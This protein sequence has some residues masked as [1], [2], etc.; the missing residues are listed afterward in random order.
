MIFAENFAR[1]YE[2]EIILG[3]SDAW[4]LSCSSQRPIDPAY[5]IEDCRMYA[6]VHRIQKKRCRTYK[7]ILVS[8]LLSKTFAV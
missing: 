7:T 4:S 1:N 5:Y 3:T 2:K 8:Y 6:S